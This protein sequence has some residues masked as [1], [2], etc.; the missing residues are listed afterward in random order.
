VTVPFPIF[1]AL[2]LLSDM[3]DRYWVLPARVSGGHTVGGFA[4]RD[5]RGVVR[6]LLYTHHA[7]DTQSRSGAAF[8]V[9][10]D[11]D[12]LGWDGPA[13]VVEYRFDREHNTPFPLARTL[14]TRPTKGGPADPE[15]LAAV[16]RDL[17][18]ADPAAQKRGLEGVPKLDA[19]GRQSVL[20]AV[21]Q[22]AGQSNDPAL[23]DAA[24]AVLRAA[25]GPAAYPR[26]EVDRI[27]ALCECRPT[28]TATHPR[29]GDGRLRLNVR[30]A[31][32]GC[33]FLVI[34]REPT[35]GGR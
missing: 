2:G 29:Q 16:T 5:D 13:R 8:D 3:G 27:V 32:N 20:A 18:S 14:S 33:N 23:R 24:T 21:F 4:S 15:R 17:N 1:H 9:A 26:E 19:A 10:L 31:A 22:L 34:D 7:Q 35:G 30:V 6:V 28:A 11:L 25:A 12:A